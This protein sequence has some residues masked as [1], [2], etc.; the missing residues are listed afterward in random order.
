[1]QLQRH[2]LP[3]LRQCQR[4]RGGELHHG[5]ALQRKA[6]AVRLQ[7]RQRGR[8]AREKTKQMKVGI[9]LGDGDS[10]RMAKMLKPIRLIRL[11][12]IMRLIR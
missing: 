5:I 1:M 12:K 10:V 6:A 3:D 8:I 4:V 9:E 2:R 11:A 7:A